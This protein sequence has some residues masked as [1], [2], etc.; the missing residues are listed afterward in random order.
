MARTGSALVVLAFATLAWLAAVLRL[1][2]Y[3]VD[4]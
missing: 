3:G 4:Y 1:A 2:G